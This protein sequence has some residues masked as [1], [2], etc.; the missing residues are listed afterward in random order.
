MPHHLNEQ[1]ECISFHPWYAWRITRLQ[2]LYLATADEVFF[3]TNGSTWYLHH[4]ALPCFKKRRTV[5]F[6]SYRSR[7]T[8]VNIHVTFCRHQILIAKVQCLC[9]APSRLDGKICVLDWMQPIIEYIY[10]LCHYLQFFPNFSSSL[11]NSQFAFQ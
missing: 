10:I 2:I 4:P 1:K 7:G 5:K 11:Q 6:A 9:C 8:F 3:S